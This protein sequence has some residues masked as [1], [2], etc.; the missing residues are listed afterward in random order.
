LAD[1]VVKLLEDDYQLCTLV[2]RLDQDW[3]PGVKGPHDEVWKVQET[4]AGGQTWIWRRLEHE[5]EMDSFAHNEGL[6]GKL[7]SLYC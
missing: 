4:A 5:T 6:L 3:R 2:F 1:A 7:P